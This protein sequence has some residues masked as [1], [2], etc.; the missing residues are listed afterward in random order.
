[1]PRYS[2]HGPAPQV[3]AIEPFINGHRSA[4]ELSILVGLCEYT[5]RHH[6]KRLHE[7]GYIHISDWH[8]DVYGRESVKIFDWGREKDAPKS[9]PMTSA[10]RQ[11]RHRAKIP[12]RT[13]QHVMALMPFTTER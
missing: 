10:E 8:R 1:M 9:R 6:L 3:T 2:P 13:L 4:R 7:S 12:V 5:V 11:R